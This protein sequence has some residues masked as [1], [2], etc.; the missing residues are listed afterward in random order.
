MNLPHLTLHQ[1]LP[2]ATLPAR[3]LTSLV[4]TPNITPALAYG[5]A[6]GFRECCTL[7]E[8]EVRSAGLA[9]RR[10]RLAWR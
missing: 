8:R 1:R 2:T 5:D 9:W 10:R 6:T 3:R 7:F 4:T